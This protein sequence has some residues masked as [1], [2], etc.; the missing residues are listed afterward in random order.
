MAPLAITS[1]L[2]P[3]LELA[4]IDRAFQHEPLNLPEMY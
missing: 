2:L 3:A 1:G 4:N